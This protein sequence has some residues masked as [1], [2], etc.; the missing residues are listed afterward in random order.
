MFL[1]IGKFC[2]LMIV[3]YC[4]L[5]DDWLELQYLVV[6]VVCVCA[7]TTFSLM[8]IITSKLYHDKKTI[9]YTVK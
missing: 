4:S 3:F 9:H 5:F 7:S 6:G 8:L 1:Q 2:V